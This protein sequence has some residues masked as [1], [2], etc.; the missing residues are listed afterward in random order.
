MQTEN[1]RARVHAGASPT[2]HMKPNS[3]HNHSVTLPD[4][5][6]NLRSISAAAKSRSD[7]S[8]L[9]QEFLDE[10]GYSER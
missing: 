10:C 9:V 2:R 7:F 3:N 8:P 4:R 5:D 1:I 6:V